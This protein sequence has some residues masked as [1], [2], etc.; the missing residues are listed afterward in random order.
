MKSYVIRVYRFERKHP[1]SLVGVVEEVGVKGKR[2]FTNIDELWEIL[3]SVK[4][5]DKTID[6]ER[7]Y[8]QR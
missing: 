2:A 5:R 3:K 4:K 8:S 6:K 7:N 1:R